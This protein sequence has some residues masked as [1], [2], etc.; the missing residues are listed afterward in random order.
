MHL[1]SALPSLP[2]PAW[3]HLLVLSR[4]SRGGGGDVLAHSRH[5]A[6]RRPGLL[7]PHWP[8]W[9]PQL[10]PGLHLASLLHLLQLAQVPLKVQDQEGTR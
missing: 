1:L 5:L 4:K 10:P 7:A 9:L 2:R 8:D 3:L 6:S